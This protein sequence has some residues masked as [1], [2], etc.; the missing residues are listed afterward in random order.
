MESRRSHEI[1]LLTYLFSWYENT[2]IDCNKKSLGN[3]SPEKKIIQ[4]HAKGGNGT[5]NNQNHIEELNVYPKRKVEF[6]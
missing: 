1:L 4:L 2:F 5:N 3:H 6:D